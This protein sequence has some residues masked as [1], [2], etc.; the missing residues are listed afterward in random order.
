MK[1][2]RT[3]SLS[4]LP[5]LV[6]THWKYTSWKKI[7]FSVLV[8]DR[9]DVESGYYQIDSGVLG[10][11]EAGKTIHVL[12]PFRSINAQGSIPHN[13]FL[14]GFEISSQL[15]APSYRSPFE[16][17]IVHTATNS[18]G[19]AVFFSVTTI[20]QVHAIHVS[21]VAWWQTDLHIVSGKYTSNILNGLEISHIPEQNIGRNYARIFGLSG[22]IINHQDQDIYFSTIW[23]GS[24]YTFD[25]D[26][27]T[28]YVKYLSF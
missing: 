7:S 21:Y 9:Q 25:F 24:K 12:L 13:V 28:P 8:E 4:Y 5:L 16:I 15:Y 1:P 11:C 14:Q 22:F 19:I 27:S 23:S 2:V 18:S 20:T 3:E 6:R 26:S 10:G 17:Q